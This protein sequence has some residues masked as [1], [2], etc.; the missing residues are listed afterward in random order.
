MRKLTI[1]R[2]EKSF[3]HCKKDSQ[4]SEAVTESY[5]GVLNFLSKSLKNTSERLYSGNA[6]GHI[7]MIVVLLKKETLSLAFFKIAPMDPLAYII[8]Q[9]KNQNKQNNYN[10]L[11]CVTT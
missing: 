4:Y 11:Y 3:N 10:T 9:K 1:K 6:S 5:I 2:K 7:H 8:E